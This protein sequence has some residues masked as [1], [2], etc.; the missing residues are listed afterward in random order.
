[1]FDI[2]AVD[3][4]GR[5]RTNDEYIMVCAAVSASVTADNIEKTNQIAIRSFRSI[6]APDVTDV[7][8]MVETTVAELKFGGTIVTEAGDMYNKPQRIIDSIF[9]Q[10]FK[11]Q[12]SLGE[13]R[14]IELAH[15]VSLA[16]R[17]FLLKEL[18]LQ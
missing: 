5:H 14:C 6:S 13:R 9:Y 15:H 1:M 12:E 4:S 7:I 3:I 2:I 11:Y 17:K 18:G 8:N 10:D 16:A